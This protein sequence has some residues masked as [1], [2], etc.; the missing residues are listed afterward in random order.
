MRI[1]D[2]GNFLTLDPDPGWKKFGSG[3]GIQDDRRQN[4]TSI[5]CSAVSAHIPPPKMFLTYNGE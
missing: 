4:C 2:Q 5:G 1:R 3:S